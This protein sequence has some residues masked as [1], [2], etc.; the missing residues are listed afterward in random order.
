MNLINTASKLILAALFVL[1]VQHTAYACLCFTSSPCEAVGN[2]EAVFIAEAIHERRAERELPDAK[3]MTKTVIRSATVSTLQISHVFFGI[4]SARV[5]LWNNNTSCAYPFEVGKTYLVFAYRAVDG[6]W[7]ASN[8][9]HTRLLESANEDLAYLRSMRKGAG[10]ALEGSV[11]QVSYD[12]ALRRTDSGLGNVSVFL[13]SP[14]NKYRAVTDARGNFELRNMVGGE[15]RVHTEPATNQNTLSEWGGPPRP[16]WTI[17]IPEQGCQTVQFSAAP[18]GSVSGRVWSGEELVHRDITIDLIHVDLPLN[19]KNGL[20]QTLGPDGSYR[21]DYLPPGRYYVGINLFTD[22]LERS[23]F[24]TIF[25]SGA[26]SQDT[27]NIVEIG[28]DQ[29]LSGYDIHLPDSHRLRT[30]EG[31]VRR[32]DGTPIANANANVIFRNVTDDRDNDFAT[33]GRDGK[34][35]FQGIEGQTYEFIALDFSGDGGGNS[36]P[37]KIKFGPTNAPVQLTIPSLEK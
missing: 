4:D 34:F 23:G 6:K 29:Q 8:C 12:L 17:K 5:D 31:V 21:F 13:V 10:S 37:V 36:T 32:P 19:N 1:F 9:S 14:T 25:Y 16:E 3:D 7:S 26:L 33:T 18:A 35:S 11:T 15:Y 22:S 28:R 27:A 20:R 2:A 30:L 24:P